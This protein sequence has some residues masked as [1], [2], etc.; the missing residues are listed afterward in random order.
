MKPFGFGFGL[1]KSGADDRRSQNKWK[2]DI[3]KW[4]Q[5]KI[6]GYKLKLFTFISIYFPLFPIN[7]SY[8]EKNR[9]FG[10]NLVQGGWSNRALL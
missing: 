3:N 8:R 4:I 10:K 9:F 2:I 1:I 6:N 7:I 5:M